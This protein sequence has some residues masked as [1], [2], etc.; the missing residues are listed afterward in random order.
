MAGYRL[1]FLG[2]GRRQQNHMATTKMVNCNISLEF[3][4]LH[5]T[6]INIDN[7]CNFEPKVGSDPL[8]N[9]FAEKIEFKFPY[10]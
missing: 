7:L 8:F 9:N 2:K 10:K 1:L 6:N 3:P 5:Y 4:I